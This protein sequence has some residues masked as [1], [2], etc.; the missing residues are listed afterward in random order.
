[1]PMDCHQIQE[2]MSK[3][4]KYM[5]FKTL[6]CDK[7]TL[8]CNY[9]QL[10]NNIKTTCLVMLVMS[11]QGKLRGWFPQSSFTLV[12][13]SQRW[14]GLGDLEH[15]YGLDLAARFTSSRS[16][17]SKHSLQVFSNNVAAA[18]WMASWLLKRDKPTIPTQNH[19]KM[20][21]LLKKF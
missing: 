9:S 15:R 16:S 21:L 4:S 20:R 12:I 11:S 10:L 5:F 3:S 2:I 13:Y 17:M 18:K 1:M 8:N 14:S 6:A 7:L 19:V